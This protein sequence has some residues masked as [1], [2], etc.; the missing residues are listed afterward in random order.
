MYVYHDRIDNSIT[1]TGM[2]V[3]MH[4]YVHVQEMTLYRLYERTF[5]QPKAAHF[6][7]STL[8]ITSSGDLN[9]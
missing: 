4:E 8:F 3:P 6:L 7:C 1:I 2:S 9:A 5:V